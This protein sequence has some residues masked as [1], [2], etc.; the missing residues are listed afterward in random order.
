MV[1]QI[2]KYNLTRTET[3]VGNIIYSYYSLKTSYSTKLII[4]LQITL[5]GTV[6]KLIVMNT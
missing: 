5:R 4:T 2:N 6:I 3:D 1:A